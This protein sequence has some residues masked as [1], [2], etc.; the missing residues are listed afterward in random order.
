MLSSAT[1]VRLVSLSA[2]KPIRVETHA[3]LPSRNA[4]R[5]ANSARALNT[6]STVTHAHVSA[7]LQLA[8]FQ[9]ITPGKRRGGHDEDDEDDYQADWDSILL[10]EEEDEPYDDPIPQEA[11]DFKLVRALFVLLVLIQGRVGCVIA[12]F[13]LLLG[14]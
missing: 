9:S 2:F 7:P 5:N 12:D 6:H 3:P 4:N 13:A 8:R 1:S 11:P 10:E 14:V